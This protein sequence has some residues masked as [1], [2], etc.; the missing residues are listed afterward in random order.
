MSVKLVNQL[1]SSGREEM[2]NLGSPF[3]SYD[4]LQTLEESKSVGEGTGWSPI[5]ITDPGKSAL[6]TFIK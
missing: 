2:D 3:L 4:F 6:F 1:N 5:Y